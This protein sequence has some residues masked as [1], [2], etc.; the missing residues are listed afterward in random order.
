MNPLTEANA[1][2]PWF[3]LAPASPVRGIRVTP[4]VLHMPHRPFGRLRSL[5]MH[6]KV[7]D[8]DC[9]IPAD[10]HGLDSSMHRSSGPQFRVQ[11]VRLPQRLGP[12]FQSH[13]GRK[14]DTAER[15]LR[16]DRLGSRPCAALDRRE[17][18]CSSAATV[19][20]T[21]RPARAHGQPR[22][23][24]REEPAVPPG[25]RQSLP[26]AVAVTAPLGNRSITQEHDHAVQTRDGEQER[27]R[28]AAAQRRL[29]AGSSAGYALA[30]RRRRCPDG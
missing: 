1:H 18:R 15:V 7:P 17:T 11:R 21:T 24:F 9:R 13:H 30:V 22:Q 2:R 12:Q 4:L 27:A 28:P 26:A 8:S 5:P 16:V 14:T 23:R 25:Q 29:P 3:G 19:R 6:R 10:R 20:A